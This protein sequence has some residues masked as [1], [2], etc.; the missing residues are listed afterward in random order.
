MNEEGQQKFDTKREAMDFAC[1]RVRECW[2]V[3]ARPLTFGDV[4]GNENR[5][6][7]D[8]WIVVWWCQ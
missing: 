2:I 6:V 1:E 4:P 8:S 3:H 7:K 5:I